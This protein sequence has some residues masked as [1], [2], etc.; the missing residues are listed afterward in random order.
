[1]KEINCIYKK[2]VALG[3]CGEFQASLKSAKSIADLATLFF[4]P[5]GIEF[6]TKHHF[7]DIE[8]FHTL[9]KTAL[10]KNNMYVDTYLS[11]RN[12]EKVLLVGKTV[13]ELTYDTPDK[14]HEVILMHGATALI[15]ASGYAVVFVTNDGGKLS[16]TKNDNAK[17]FV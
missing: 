12:P 2:A 10:V 13:A 4:T 14:R 17:I 16:T 5:K 7:P 3:L 6:C 9:D 8:S 11:L 1:M 15:K